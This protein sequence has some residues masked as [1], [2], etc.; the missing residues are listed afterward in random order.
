M[1]RNQKNHRSPAQLVICPV[2]G[3]RKECL[4][5]GGL[6]QHIQAKHKEYQP[7]TPS[8]PSAAAVDYSILDSESSSVNDLEMST[9]I[10]PDNDP[11]GASDAFGSESE[12]ESTGNRDRDR[13]RDHDSLSIG[14]DFEIPFLPS[15]Q[16]DSP[17]R[18]SEASNVDYHPII[19]G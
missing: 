11:A 12:S 5:Y 2:E 16:P 17:S 10:P 8:P 14:F 9:G 13:D 7:G 19:N 6:T 4:S 15:S 18:E 3:C 1:H